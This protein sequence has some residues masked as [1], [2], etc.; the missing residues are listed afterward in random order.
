MG[1]EVGYFHSDSK[2]VDWVFVDHPSYPRPGGLYSDANGVYGDNQVTGMA[3]TLV[4]MDW[5]VA[6][7]PNR[8]QQ[9][10]TG[11]Q[12][13]VVHCSASICAAVGTLGIICNTEM[14]G[15]DVLLQFRYML[16]CLA[17]LEAPLQLN[18]NG[19]T[20]GEDC[21]FIGTISGSCLPVHAAAS[22]VMLS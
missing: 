13:A 1:N 11:F 14:R 20:Y 18:L 6:R 16:L 5:Q 22:I 21:I 4:L 9:D 12:G 15:C 2:G 7:P 3:Q 10:S 8:L 19:S 17:A